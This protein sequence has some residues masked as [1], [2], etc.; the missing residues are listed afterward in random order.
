MPLELF[1]LIHFVIVRSMP[2]RPAQTCHNFLKMYKI[3]VRLSL[4]ER[5]TNLIFLVTSNCSEVPD[6]LT[7]VVASSNSFVFNCT[8]ISLSLISNSFNRTY[9]SHSFSFSCSSSLFNSTAL[10][11][12]SPASSSETT[13]SLR[14][15]SLTSFCTSHSTTDFR[16]IMAH[17]RY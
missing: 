15:L 13:F 7:V 9:V 2:F 6:D 11:T 14:R 5:G 8:A 4:L 3:F 16:V 17:E 10:S 1:L 12:L